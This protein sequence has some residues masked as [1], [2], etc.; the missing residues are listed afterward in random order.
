LNKN[1][2]KNS[3]SWFFIF[4]ESFHRLPTKKNQKSDDKS[5]FV[6]NGT[7]K[8]KENRSETGSESDILGCVEIS[9]SQ[10]SPKCDNCIRPYF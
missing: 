9:N 6:D 8:D 4:P 3:S 10:E 5:E 1:V 2:K 7:N